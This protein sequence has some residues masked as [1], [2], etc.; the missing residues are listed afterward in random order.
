MDFYVVVQVALKWIVKLLIKIHSSRGK[1][2]KLAMSGSIGSWQR[3]RRLGA[4]CADGAI[5]L[6]KHIIMNNS[7]SVYLRN[8]RICGL[9]A[10]G[11]TGLGRENK[12]GALGLLRYLF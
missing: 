1:V 4:D 10:I 9:S 5:F 7:L 12:K 3:L 6:A 8:R 11:A 2:T